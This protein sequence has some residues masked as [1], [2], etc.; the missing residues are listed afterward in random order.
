[1]WYFGLEYHAI[2]N[3]TSYWIHSLVVYSKPT[4]LHWAEV[5][6]GGVTD[7][8]P[9][10]RFLPFYP[11][12]PSIKFLKKSNFTLFEHLFGPIFRKLSIFCNF[13]STFRNLER[14]YT[15]YNRFSDVKS[16]FWFSLL[17]KEQS[18]SI[19]VQD[20]GGPAPGIFNRAYA[21]H[22]S[23]VNDLCK[24]MSARAVCCSWVTFCFLYFFIF[25]FSGGDDIQ[26]RNEF[27]CVGVWKWRKTN[28]KTLYRIR[29]SK[30]RIHNSS[31]FTPLMLWLSV[32][33]CIAVCLSQLDIQ[34]HV[35]ST[36]EWQTEKEWQSR[37]VNDKQCKATVL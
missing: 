4:I 12:P 20:F 11:A 29:K 16:F 5:L 14:V 30:T 31:E 37:N 3:W 21:W 28:H 23:I 10:S 8:S 24:L 17:K 36:Y 1:M 25:S 35:N 2:S 27:H 9:S 26:P 19:S 18:L 34:C 6:T 15:R 32:T 22:W 33:L 7:W 13:P